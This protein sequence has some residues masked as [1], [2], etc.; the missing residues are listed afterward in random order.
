[1][2]G[3]VPIPTSR[4]SDYF[5]RQRLVQQFQNDQLELFQLQDQI[6]T[7]Q[8]IIL[9]SDD[10]SAALR[11]ITL[12]RL[13]ERKDQLQ[14]NVQTGQSFLAATDSA[15]ADIATTLGDLRGLVLGVAGTTNS[16]LQRDAA[17]DEINRALEQLVQTGNSKFR[18]RYLFAGSETSTQPYLLTDGV[19]EYV[20]NEK[21]TFSYSDLNMLFATNS[22]G[23]KV[24]GGISAAVL[25]N[26][27]LSPQTS[28]STLLTNLRSGEGIS[29]NG[30]LQISDGTLSSVVDISSASTLGDVARLIET[31]PPTGRQVTVSITGQGLTLQLD[32]AGGGT[33]S[34]TE[35]GSGS[36]AAELGILNISGVIPPN[37]LVGTDLDPILEPTSRLDDMLGTKATAKVDTTGTNNDIRFRAT[38]N[39]TAYDGVAIQFVDDN[40]WQTGPGITAGNEYVQFDPAP[41]AAL[42]SLQFTGVN[43]D[44]LLTANTT[45]NSFNGVQIDVLSTVTPG[46]PP[47]AVYDTINKVL[48]IDLESD[49]SSNA[50][51]VIAAVAGIA[52]NPFTATLDTSAEANSG[53]GGIG[54]PPINQPNYANTGNSGGNADTLYIYIEPGV[55]TANQ[56]V[57][58]VNTE[59]TFNAELDANDS[60]STLTAGT[61]LVSSTSTATTSG[62]SGNSLD[63]TNGIQIVNDNQTVTLN[64]STAVTVEDLTNLIN[65]SDAGLLAEINSTGTGLDIRSRISGT[66]FQIG[67]NGGRT[68][69]DLGIRTLTD[70][71]NLSN[72]NYGVGVPTRTGTLPLTDPPGPDQVDFRITSQDSLGAYVDLE[73][74]LDFSG[75][76]TMGDVVTLINTNPRNNASGVDIFAQ[77]AQNGNGI[78]L[79]D[80]NRFTPTSPLT[81]SAPVWNSNWAHTAEKQATGTI[82]FGGDTFVL[83]A[84]A[85]GAVAG[86]EGDDLND[87]S[88]AVTYGGAGSSSYNPTTNVLTVDLIPL[89]GVATIADLRAVINA[90]TDFTA[91]AST[92]DANTITALSS[93]SYVPIGGSY[94]AITAEHLGLIPA[95]TTQTSSTTGTLTGTDRNFQETASIFTTLVRLRDTLQ[96]NDI[97]A[98]ERTIAMIDS[99]IDRVSFARA[100]AG[101]R[102]QG[103][104]LATTNLQGEEIQLRTALSDEIDVDL[105]EAISAFTARQISMEASLKASASVLQLSLL[106]FL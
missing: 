54:S 103:L 84:L 50:N 91:G 26:V 66:N 36:A 35:V 3:L 8:R 40:L 31:N 48:T 7:G 22:P 37:P 34:V 101:A 55:T 75:A 88:L 76:T 2:S 100:E 1:M 68:A 105:V 19:V 25:G 78:E 46:N 104:E 92:G 42:A 97:L 17:V 73:I 79:I 49:S 106:D 85:G 87:A 27:D 90:G 4:I 11:A 89:S 16:Q 98:L 39:G 74:D 32:T 61:G 71:T 43:N 10:P 83:T 77:M 33:L 70:Q 94:E 81:V 53:L 62:G 96:A 21:Q 57:A 38:S 51:Q 20:G 72:L 14:I 13:L 63:L 28:T 23:S 45:G 24:F 41:R 56:V 82:T 95:G 93:T 15:L 12:Q 6:S 102:Q 65:G 18:G 52:G 30:A 9:P 80:R 86:A 69:T 5:A 58:A 99:D 64:L 44:L 59:G 29:P 67:E 47:T 60:L